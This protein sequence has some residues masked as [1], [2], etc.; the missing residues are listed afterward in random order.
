MIEGPVTKR[1]FRRRATRNAI[2]FAAIGAGLLT[3]LLGGMW[4][5]GNLRESREAAV[6]QARSEQLSV[7][8]AK[9]AAFFADHAARLTET[10]LRQEVIDLFH[11]GDK[12]LLAAEAARL[13]TE[14]PSAL[15]LRFLLPGTYELDNESVPPLSYVG[16]DLLTAA[17]GAKDVIVD[18]HLLGAGK[19]HIALARRVTDAGGALVGMIHLSLDAALIGEVMSGLSL[20]GGYAELRQADVPNPKAYGKTGD[21]AGKVGNPLIVPVKGTRF[22]LAYWPP[23]AN[24]ET[25]ENS[26]LPVLLALIAAAG[27]AVF[28]ILRRRQAPAPAAKSEVLYYGAIEAIMKGA[29]PGM[30]KLI[31]HLPG[32][33]HKDEVAREISRGMNGEDITR[34]AQSAAAAASDTN[35]NE[36]GDTANAAASADFFDLTASEEKTPTPQTQSAKATAEGRINKA[37]FRAYD[38]RGVA[39]KDLTPETV[40]LIGQAIGSEAQKREEKTVIVGRDGRN[41][42]QELLEALS[43]GLRAAGCDVIDIGMVPT[44]VLYF[45]THFLGPKSGVILTGSHNPPEYNGLKIV[46]GGETLSE[47][48]IQAIYRRIVENDFQSGAGQVKTMEINTDYIRRI[49]EDIP[50]ALGRSFKLVVD[51]GNGVTG[52]L[53]PQLYRALG[54]DI[55]ELYCEID[56]NFPNH[57]P[58]PSQPKNLAELIAKVKAENAD[59]GFAFDGD[60]DRLGVV[61]NR[62]NIIWPDRQIMLLA[63]DVLSR[64]PG[65]EI[66][67]DVKCSRHLKSVIEAAGGKPLMWKTGHSLIKG[68]MKESGALLAGE[69][70]GHIF[71]KERWYGFDDAL[72]AGARMLEVLMKAKAAPADVFAALPEGKSTP[73]LRVDLPE[74]EH[75]G[76][77]EEIG[78]GVPFKGAEIITIDGLRAEY[79][80]GWGL[81]RPSNTMPCLI[82]RFEADNDAA[83]ERIQTTFRAKLLSIKPDLVLPF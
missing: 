63:K 21:P 37:I 38:I 17:E 30:E 56:G 39:G 8:A 58:D 59:I 46:L 19:Q 6:E 48:S 79:P 25:G 78:E 18:A 82:L 69:M 71:F 62:G 11:Q 24:I 43:D 15:K 42:G 41:S 77:M 64:N 54:H 40:R 81:V 20:P 12:T 2:W 32:K 26:L 47:D 31:P 49:S 75:A 13:Q 29:H 4:F 45:A 35:E 3:L 57:H 1:R 68:K 66:I 28:I 50:V 60:G 51:S 33:V 74:D 36:T 9:V 73:E 10:A 80:D 5:Y 22:A 27:A 61:D 67:Y 14:F 65:A 76:F 23:G 16:L 44:P 72:Y 55:I 34:I 52:N 7:S 83:L 70:S 53:A